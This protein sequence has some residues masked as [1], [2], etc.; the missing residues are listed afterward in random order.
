M[1]QITNAFQNGPG[2]I[3]DFMRGKP[4]EEYIGRFEHFSLVI[5]VS[6]SLNVFYFIFTEK[7]KEP[8][9]NPSTVETPDPP[10]QI[11]S[12]SL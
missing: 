9:R 6:L 2:S 10:D 12:L 3:G 4:A 11:P 1:H 5:F 7:Q 8:V